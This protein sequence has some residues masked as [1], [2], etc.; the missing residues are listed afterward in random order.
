MRFPLIVKLMA[1]IALVILLPSTAFLAHVYS[2]SRAEAVDLELQRMR[3]YSREI[4]TEIDSFIVSQQNL[5]RYATISNELRDYLRRS[6]AHRE[7]PGFSQWLTNWKGISDSIAEVFVMDA[8]GV[9]V[10]ASNP[11]FVGKPYAF[12]PYFRTAIAGE[13]YVS[14]WMVG[15]TSKKAGIYL[16]SPIRLGEQVGGVLVI[17]VDPAPIDHIIQ[18]SFGIGMQAFVTNGA[19]VVLAHYDQSI[20]YATVDDLSA[21]EHSAIRESQQ[22]ADI[23]QRSLKLSSLRADMARVLPGETLTSA[24]YGFRGEQKIAAMTGTHFHRWVAGIAAPFSA[25][26]APADR[27]VRSVLPL[28]AVILL[29]AAISSFYVSRYLARPLQHLLAAVT[30]FGAG[31]SSVRAAVEG[32]DEVGRLAAAFN[33]MAGRIAKQTNE[34]EQRVAERTAELKDAYER[35]KLVSLVDPL[36]GCFNR[37]YM[38]EHLAEELARAL[39]YRSELSVLMCDIDFF[40]RVNDTHGHPVGDRVLIDVATML[41]T[42]SRQQIDWVARYGGEEFLMVLPESSQADAALLAE[43]LRST[44]ET[45]EF[46]YAETALQLTVSFGVSAC[47]HEGHETTGTLLAR[48]DKALYKAKETGR[49]RVVAG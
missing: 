41:R 4:A 5:T 29:F 45:S 40:K 42:G 43:R 11:D 26:E 24:V 8:S 15:V 36:T 37:R 20:R 12:R 44:I 23:E 16:S 14:D 1:A 21:A 49:N 38:D 22:F 34:L 2:S 9:C 33:D 35:I 28:A 3:N 7:A 6:G 25:I 30:R 10:A 31:D 47:R 32:G 13:D 46:K 18:R 48:A 27:L 17:K 39:R 19:G